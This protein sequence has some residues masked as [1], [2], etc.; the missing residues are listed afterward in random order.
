VDEAALGQCRE[1]AT[2]GVPIDAETLRK[3][4]LGRQPAG[5]ETPGQHFVPQNV[6]DLAPSGQTFAPLQEGHAGVPPKAVYSDEELVQ[7]FV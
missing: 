3:F 7:E 6:G 5:C 4:R 2:D 1:S